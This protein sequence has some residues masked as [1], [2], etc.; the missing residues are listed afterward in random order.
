MDTNKARLLEEVFNHFV[1]PPKLPGKPFEDPVALLHELGRRLQKACVTLRPLGPA[2]IQNT[3]ISSLDIII[4]LNQDFL[5]GESLLE[6]FH[7][8][9]ESDNDNWLALHIIEQ[10]AA[11]LIHK[12]IAY[13][14]FNMLIPYLKLFIG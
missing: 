5:S 3:L 6:A 4:K 9:A 14:L 12:D 10:N 1:L 8:L 13:V 7:L 11:L 2:R